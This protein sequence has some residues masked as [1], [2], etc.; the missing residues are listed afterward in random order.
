MEFE[1]LSVFLIKLKTISN[2]VGVVVVV[3]DRMVVGLTNTHAIGAYHPPLVSSTN[4]TDRHDI[5]EVLLKVALNTIAMTIFCSH[6]KR[7]CTLQ[8]LHRAICFSSDSQ[9]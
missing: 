7:V 2:Q 1:D 6:R 3:I 8:P 4:K 5:T 9:K